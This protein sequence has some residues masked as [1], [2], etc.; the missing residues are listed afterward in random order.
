[1]KRFFLILFS[2]T[3]LLVLAQEVDIKLYQKIPM[4]DGIHLSANIYSPV[5]NQKS[6]PVDQIDYPPNDKTECHR[7]LTQR[8]PVVLGL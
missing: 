7:L 3:S 6:H 5:T 8:N 1:M 2:L 4:R